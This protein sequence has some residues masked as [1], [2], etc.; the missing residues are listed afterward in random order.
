MSVEDSSSS[1]SGLPPV[2]SISRCARLGRERRERAEQRVRRLGV[3]PAEPQLLELGRLEGA[4][5]AVAGGEQD[6]DALGLEPA[7]R[8]HQR[9]GAARVE[10]VRVVDQ[11]QHAAPAPPPRRAA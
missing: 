11:A 6:R 10:P 7:R 5:V 9:L 8:E 2:P 1:A 3:E 4:H